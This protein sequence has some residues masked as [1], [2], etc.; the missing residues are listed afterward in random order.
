MTTE[1]PY[2]FTRPRGLGGKIAPLLARMGWT[3]GGHGYFPHLPDMGG[4]F[5]ALG[6]GVPAGGTLPAVHQVDIAATV[7]RL[8]AID[9]PLQSEGRPIEGIG[10][11]PG[12]RPGAPDATF[13]DDVSE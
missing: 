6:R 1:P 11:Q 12:I 7:A 10:V 9:P 8:L 4:V 2:S 3:L 13:A 5:M